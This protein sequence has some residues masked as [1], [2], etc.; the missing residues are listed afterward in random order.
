[1]E[2]LERSIPHSQNLIIQL[3]KSPV[4][5]PSSRF[6]Q[7]RSPYEERCPPPEPFLSIL[8]GPQRGSPSPRFPSQSPTE[9][10]PPSPE[11][12]HPTLK[13]PGRRALLQ[14]LQKRS[15]YKEMPI[16]RAFSECL[17]GFPARKPPFQVPFT[18]PPWRETL[19]PQSPFSHI[20][21]SR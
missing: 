5:E 12:L 6:P 1:M 11:P 14:V 19:H 7:K 17:S 18:E 21:K 9:R 16:P 4:D 20:S 10:D 2:P 8:Q 13:V 3:S 15:L